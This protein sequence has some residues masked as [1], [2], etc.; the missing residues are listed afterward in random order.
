MLKWRFQQKRKNILFPS[1]RLFDILIKY[2]VIKSSS[3]AE[4]F[5]FLTEQF[6]QGRFNLLKYLVIYTYSMRK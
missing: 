6:F 3:C 1:F 5:I 2:A 4:N